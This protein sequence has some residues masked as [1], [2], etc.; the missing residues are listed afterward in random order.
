MLALLGSLVAGV[1][2]EDAFKSG[3][4]PPP[5]RWTFAIPSDSVAVQTTGFPLSIDFNRELSLSE[6]QL[7]VVPAPLEMSTPRLT[8]SRRNITVDRI[9]LDPS[10]NSQYLLISGSNL[11]NTQI[12]WWPVGPRDGGFFQGAIS[13]SDPSR[14]P[15]DEV[16]IFAIPSNQPFNPLEPHGFVD[17]NPRSISQLVVINAGDTE[18]SYA[19]TRLPTRSK[20]FVI[21]IVDSNRDG[22]YDP[23]RDWWGYHGIQASNDPVEVPAESLFSPDLVSDADIRLGPPTP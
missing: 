12:L 23:A 1:G 15:F 3:I 8:S 21:A 14:T 4:I 11:V 6:I 17:L 9:V 18:H 5:I 16:M 22:L 20:Y 10:A 7:R 19:M 13:S 2:C